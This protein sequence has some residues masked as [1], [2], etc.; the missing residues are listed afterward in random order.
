MA[1]IGTIVDG[2]VAYQ[3]TGT[4]SA[5]T[6]ATKKGALNETANMRGSAF[7]GVT[8]VHADQL[9]GS[10]ANYFKADT[11]MQQ[12]IKEGQA[13]S[14]V[15]VLAKNDAS[16]INGRIGADNTPTVATVDQIIS[17]NVG[18]YADNISVA[19][20]AFNV[21]SKEYADDV[22][23]S[24]KVADI[25]INSLTEKY[26]ISTESK[27]SSP[28]STVDEDGNK[29]VSPGKIVLDNEGK[30]VQVQMATIKF[31]ELNEVKI[32]V[33]SVETDND[34]VSHPIVNLRALRLA[35]KTANPDAN[36][37]EILK[38]AVDKLN[39]KIDI[40]IVKG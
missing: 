40:G 20:V 14:G 35:L 5:T 38:E 10:L 19:N 6:V 26:S 13:G 37:A 27:T 1:T 18:V 4:G 25:V 8:F 15:T 17:G 12:I 22:K 29:V 23:G 2:R 9:T 39:S 33:L 28:T 3:N 24:D 31:A 32:R 30:P 16:K 36:V 21:T 7:E 34:G 11:Q